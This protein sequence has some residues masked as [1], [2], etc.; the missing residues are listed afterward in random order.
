MSHKSCGVWGRNLSRKVQNLPDLYADK[1]L[2]STCLAKYS[3]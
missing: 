3:I 1:E 2:R